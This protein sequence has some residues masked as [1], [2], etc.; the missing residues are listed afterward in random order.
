M[1]NKFSE[2]KNKFNENSL[3]LKHNIIIKFNALFI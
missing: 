1:E 3:I 2:Y